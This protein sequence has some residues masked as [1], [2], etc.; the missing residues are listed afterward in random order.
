MNLE[1]VYVADCETDGLL[2]T[3]TKIHT[4]GIGWKSESKWNIKDTSDYENMKKVLG[5]PTK[6]CV[7]HNGYLFD[8]KALE[9]VLGIEVKA[10]IIDTLPLAWALFPNRLKY[11]LEF[12]ATDYGLEKPKVEAN[13]WVGLSVD[14][15][16][17]IEYYERL[18]RTDI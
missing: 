7:F 16:N 17:I 5:D 3:L 14:E 9:K 4:F 8:K 15:E 10:F 2:D 1:N 11:G 6:V 18:N 12:F 13:E